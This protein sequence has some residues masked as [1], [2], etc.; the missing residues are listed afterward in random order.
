MADPK[1]RCRL[2][3]HRR[4]V[5]VESG[6][7][8]RSLER[9]APL[10]AWKGAVKAGGRGGR[11]YWRKSRGYATSCKRLVQAGGGGRGCSRQSQSRG[12][13]LSHRLIWVG[14]T[15]YEGGAAENVHIALLLRG[16]ANYCREFIKFVFFK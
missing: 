13:Y 9:S 5:R 1:R 7:P 15:T 8:R 14:G 16:G 11:G 2:R 3:P 6:A 4:T 10:T 12:F